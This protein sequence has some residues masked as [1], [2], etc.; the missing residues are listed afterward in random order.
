MQFACSGFNESAKLYCLETK[1][2]QN[3]S[4]LQYR[5]EDIPWKIPRIVHKSHRTKCRRR[6]W[7]EGWKDRRIEGKKE[8]RKD[9]RKEG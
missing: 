8:G 4:R 6:Y 2:L 5:V 1:G 9:E 7:K 3:H